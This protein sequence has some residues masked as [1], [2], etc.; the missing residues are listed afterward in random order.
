[1][2]R[3]DRS[4]NTSAAQSE[5]AGVEMVSRTLTYRPARNRT[6]FAVARSGGTAFRKV[7]AFLR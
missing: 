6:T 2:A 5:Y 4:A 1:M 3:V 7:R